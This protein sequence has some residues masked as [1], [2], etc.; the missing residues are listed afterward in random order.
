MHCPNCD[1]KIDPIAL[2]EFK[3]VTVRGEP[4]E[5]SDNFLRCPLCAEEWSAENFDLALEAYNV[6]RAKHH[7][8]QPHEIKSFRKSLGL[9]QEE[10]ASLLGWSE[11]TINRYEKGSLQEKSHDNSLRMIMTREGLQSIIE[12]E[13]YNLPEHKIKKLKERLDINLPDLIEPTIITEPTIF[14]GYTSFS[15]AKFK[16]IVAILCGREGVWKTNL[17]KLLWYSD[18]FH[19]R[20]TS[21]G[22]TGLQYVRDHY[23]PVVKEWQFLF[24]VLVSR[25]FDSEIIEYQDFTGEKIKLSQAVDTSI[26]RE[27]EIQTV[28]IVKNILGS[29]NA[30]A[31]SDLSHQEKAWLETKQKDIIPYHHAESLLLKPSIDH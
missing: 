6:Y 8:L 5:V 10:L 31:I 25:E 22:L 18:F 13:N 27:S 9:T 28:Q 30:K 17:N 24:A 11:A 12:G 21:N 15:W 4:I 19:F 29:M 14:T 16:A 26:L 3:T 1:K 20:A 23:G 7:L 2:R